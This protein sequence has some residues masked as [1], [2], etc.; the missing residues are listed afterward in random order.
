MPIA[1]RVV[2]MPEGTTPDAIRERRHGWSRSASARGFRYSPRLHID[3]WGNRARRLDLLLRRLSCRACS[4][5][6]SSVSF[7]PTTAVLGDGSRFLL[8]EL[9]NRYWLLVIAWRNSPSLGPGGHRRRLREAPRIR[10]PE[11]WAS[12]GCGPCAGSPA[13]S[14]SFR[15]TAGFLRGGGN[16][17]LDFAPRALGILPLQ[18]ILHTGDRAAGTRS[19]PVPSGPDSSVPD[20]DGRAIESLSLRHRHAAS[21][22]RRITTRR[23]FPST[24]ACGS[25]KAMLATAAAV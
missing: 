15:T 21:P 13:G 8:R 11:D 24:T 5:G 22:V 18:G 10:R 4:S 2:L 14:R 20:R 6:I 9:R 25:P 17:R 19:R 12:A 16:S 3:L 23:T 1:S 7:H